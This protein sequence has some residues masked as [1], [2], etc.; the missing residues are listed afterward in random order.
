MF[1]SKGQFINIFSLILIGFGLLMDLISMILFLKWNRRK[2]GPSGLPM[3]SIVFYAIA[4]KIKVTPIFCK[5]KLLD[6]G[7]L[8]LIYIISHWIIPLVDYFFINVF[9]K[10]LKD[11]IKI[12]NDDTKHI[13]VKLHAINRMIKLAR[14]KDENKEVVIDILLGKLKSS[15]EE[16]I[17]ESIIHNL[18]DLKNEKII[19]GLVDYVKSNSDSSF[20]RKQALK[21]LK[22]QNSSEVKKELEEIKKY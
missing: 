20:S 19:E 4:L 10:N 15:Q 11:W 14:K 3:I 7:L 8:V 16:K 18:S 12:L 22:E 1:F 6:F 2:Y 9:R 17:L 21:I 5:N 13:N